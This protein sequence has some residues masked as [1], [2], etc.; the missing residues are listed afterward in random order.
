MGCRAR[1]PTYDELA[2]LVNRLLAEVADLK[3]QLKESETRRAELEIKLAKAT[4]NSQ[5]SSKPPSSDIVKPKKKGNGKGKKHGK[6]KI[7]G[8]RGHQK[9]E[10][11]FD[12]SEADHAHAHVLD[13][14]PHGGDSPLIPLH[15]QTK[16]LFQYELVDK[17]VE[18]HAHLAFGYWCESCGE[19]HHAVLPPEIRR[20]GI[21]GPKLTSCIGILKGG[22]HASYSTIRKFLSDVLKI[23]LADGTLAKIVQKVSS[24][25]EVPYAQLL[26]QAP[27][28]PILNI[29]ETG[30][31]ENGKLMWTWCFRAQLFTLFHIADSR[32][33]KILEEVLGK[34][35]EAVIGSDHFSAYRKYMENAPILVQFCLAHLIRELKFLVES[36]DKAIA[37]YGRRVLESLKRMFKLIHRRGKIPEEQFRRL[38]EKKRDAF[39]QMARRTQAGGGAATL[40]KRFRVYGHDYFTFITEPGIDPT[41]NVAE[42]AIRF[43]VIDRKVTQG[44][45][46]IRG[47]KWCERIWTTIATCAQQG[48]SAFTYIFEA[49]QASFSKSA[50]PSLLLNT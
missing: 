43:C 28:E 36:S 47:R 38:M 45:R 40:A 13:D 33:S 16:V 5:N 21:A 14:C 46:S 44:T 29:D 37:A 26:D 15:D 31:K 20:G 32:G 18:L 7:G 24:A 2:A 49:V 39:L 19:I 3:E 41:N 1:K 4:K 35:C 8:Q 23:Q 10:R 6:R 12:L 42:Q 11:E 27:L 30:H 34:E 48:R 25:L 50:P 22:C 9:H 17:P